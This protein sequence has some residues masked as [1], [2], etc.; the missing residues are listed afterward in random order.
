MKKKP[1]NRAR[2]MARTVQL[3]R[4]D[5]Y[6]LVTRVLFIS[7]ETRTVDSQSDLRFFYSYGLLRPPSFLS[8][9]WGELVSRTE[10]NMPFCACVCPYAYALMR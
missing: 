8:S 5:G 10:S 2:V 9:V 1:F 4:H 3:L 7:A 6:C